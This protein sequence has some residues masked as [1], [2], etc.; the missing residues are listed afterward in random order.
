[1]AR[2]QATISDEMIQY[3]K[4]NYGGVGQ[5]FYYYFYDTNGNPITPSKTAYVQMLADMQAYGIGLHEQILD[6]FKSQ[7]DAQLAQTVYRTPNWIRAQILL[8]QYGDIVSILNN[9]TFTM[10]YATVNAA[11][12]IFTQ[13]AVNFN[14]GVIT[15][16]AAVS[17]PPTTPSSPQ[18]T[19]LIAYLKT[20]L[21]AGTNIQGIFAPADKIKIQGTVYYDGQDPTI[22]SDVIAALNAY[23]ANLQFDG[24]V[25]MSDIE[26]TIL[27]VA[28][29]KDWLPNTIEVTPN[30]GSPV[31]LINAGTIINKDTKTYSGYL[32]QDTA[33]NDFASTLT[34]NIA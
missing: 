29:V 2:T 19:A 24:T 12:R 1:M 14:N 22:Q 32:V 21:G 6:Y 30:I 7:A 28:G 16:K 27:S 5:P 10:G 8:F 33:P 17:N 18:Q 20:I 11:K 34:F 4:T 23:I 26:T 3:L 13:A 25:R 15:V 9:T 31:Y